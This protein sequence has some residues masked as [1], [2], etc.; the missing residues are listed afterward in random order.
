VFQLDNRVKK[1]GVKVIIVSVKKQSDRDKILYL[2]GNYQ[3]GKKN[4]MLQKR[5]LEIHEIA[6]RRRQFGEN[7]LYT[8]PRVSWWRRAVEVLREPMLLLLLAACGVYF[9]MGEPTEGWMMVVSIVFVLAIELVQEQRSEKALEALQR[10]SQAK[11]R[12]YR[13]AVLQD[14]DSEEVVVGDWVLLTEGE[15]APADGF[16]R[17]VHDLSM[18]ESVLTGESVAVEKNRDAPVFQG[19]TVASGS[20][21]LEVSAVG[22][23]TELGKLGKFIETI[24]P[25]PTPLQRQIDRFVRQMGWVGIG[26]FVVVFVINYQISHSMAS[27]FLFSLTM[28]MALIPEEIPVAF[29]TFMALGAYRMSGKKI[30]AKQ[31]KTV[32]SLGAATVICLDKTGTITENRMKVAE[33]VDLSGENLVLYAARLA[34]EPE[35]FDPMEKAIVEAWAAEVGERLL[36]PENLIMEYPL[37]GKP[38]MMTHVYAGAGGMALASAKGAVERLLRVC[39]L[40]EQ[41]A[42]E[43]HEKVHTLASKGFRVLAVASADA[44]PAALP[45]EQDAF[46]WRLQGL[47]AFY[48]PPK[49]Q[50][51]RVFEQLATAGIEVKM[52]T[53]DH[54]STAL[55]IA[56]ESGLPNNGRVLTGA[57]MEQMDDTTLQS[58]VAE[59]Q[60]FA[61][62]F[63]EA[64]LRIVEALKA[65][66]AVVAMTGDGVNDGP[67]LRAAQIGVAMGARGTEIA[68]GAAA[69]V[70]LD[71]NLKRLVTAVR[72]GRRIYSN[73]RKA[74][75]YVISIHIP[76]VLVVVVP[77]VFGWPYLHILWPIHVIFM[78]LVMDP[79]CAVAFEN[80]PAEANV[81]RQKPRAPAAALFSW[82]EL[83]LSVVQGL[84]ITTAVL[85]MYR[86]GTGQGYSEEMV[87][88]LVFVTMIFSNIFLTF[89]NRSFEYTL[90]K[91]IFYKNNIIRWVTLASLGMLAAIVLIPG[92]A[93]LFM[94]ERLLWLDFLYCLL[95]ALA[96]TW[97]FELFKWWRYGNQRG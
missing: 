83:W 46:N 35:P 81:M 91:T 41:T 11:V 10:F 18:D 51:R 15:R 64:K 66:G 96:G 21:I 40:D 27:A 73:L 61:R 92:L 74:I 79:T 70:L 80:E 13:G 62:V 53:G 89:T 22:A 82:P 37:G 58:A 28:A 68:K 2:S 63:P 16:L 25:T 97:W 67:A 39:R 85:G 56:R 54:P 72:M 45:A 55:H 14:I 4:F 47:V 48:D 86:Y 29:T 1:R 33:T 23:A 52:I 88:S 31:P 65:N 26:A 34:S 57:E 17:E 43:V 9:A 84:M 8:R 30:L 44:D 50:V 78:E 20:G 42:T 77:L 6:E 90:V 75:R 32:E 19:T 87:R 95:A 76:I 36:L 49:E 60:V 38:P 24:D 94:M 71:D 5:G 93:H 12:V 7:K 59:V 69:L 3:V